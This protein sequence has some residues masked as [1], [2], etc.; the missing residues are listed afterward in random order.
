MPIEWVSPPEEPPPRDDGAAI[1]AYLQA[2]AP[3]VYDP[4]SGGGS[5]P[6]EAQ[7]LGLRAYP[8]KRDSDWGRSQGKSAVSG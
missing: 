3:P 1:L 4:F 2:K 7:R 8:T 6:L 5:I